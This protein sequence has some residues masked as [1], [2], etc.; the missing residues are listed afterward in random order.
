MAN[1]FHSEVFLPKRFKAPCFRGKLSYSLHAKTEAAN[2]R[3]GAIKL[4]EM[5]DPIASNAQL[6]EVEA[7]VDAGTIQKQVWRQALNAEQDIVLVVQPD[8]FVRTVWINLKTDQHATLNSSKYVSQRA[9]A[10]MVA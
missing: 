5:F 8:G 2:D 3:Y 1:L 9:W 7:G 10:K 4:P 6:I